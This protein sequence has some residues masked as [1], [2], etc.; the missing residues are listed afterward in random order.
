MDKKTHNAATAM[1]KMFA[2]KAFT[3]AEDFVN[4]VKIYKKMD[5]SSGELLYSLYLPGKDGIPVIASTV[6]FDV[7]DES[8]NCR[9]EL[10]DTVGTAILSMTGRS[11]E[12]RGMGLP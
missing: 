4:K 7:L 6:G 9:P 3:D 5:E 11:E 1:I 2:R 10:G 8:D 12:F